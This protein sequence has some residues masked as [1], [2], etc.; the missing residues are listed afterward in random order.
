MKDWTFTF[1]YLAVSAVFTLVGLLALFLSPASYSR[2]LSRLWAV[3]PARSRGAEVQRRLV[4]LVIAAMGLYFA[5]GIVRDAMRQP[6]S[7]AHH[8][9]V[10]P[11]WLPLV[12]GCFIC[13]MGLYL[14]VQP[15]FLVNWS[16]SRLFAGR[17]LP[18]STLRMW[19]VGFR[20]MGALMTYSSV[21]LF[22]LWLR[23]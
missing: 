10:G 17:D 5:S 20:A 12:F 22:R 18:R 7:L 16:I 23:H 21:G 13:P 8:V 15:E 4:G 6:A 14:L 1:A 9:A 19:R 2:V 11:P 3:P